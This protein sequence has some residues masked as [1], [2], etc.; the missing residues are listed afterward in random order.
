MEKII[1]HLRSLPKL[2]T[3]EPDVLREETNTFVGCS[4]NRP[5]SKGIVLRVLSEKR[6]QSFDWEWKDQGNTGAV[7][8]L[9][10]VPGTRQRI[11]TISVKFI[12]P[13]K[14][15]IFGPRVLSEKQRGLLGAFLTH[16]NN[17]LT[18]PVT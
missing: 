13:K 10:K 14:I 11:Q 17:V 16:L 7:R 18:E 9:D 2:L 12:S 15:L 1:E 3:K 6:L 5:V 8:L 4:L